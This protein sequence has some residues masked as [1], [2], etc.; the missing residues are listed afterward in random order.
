M[1]FTLK[2]MT[3]ARRLRIGAVVALIL[4]IPLCSYAMVA[5]LAGLSQPA[6]PA[7]P[8]SAAELLA[9]AITGIPLAIALWHLIQMLS[10]IEGGE[11][12]T[13]ATIAHLGGFALFVLISALISILASPII[14]LV[15]LAIDG[16]DPSQIMM[17]FD[18]GDFF[19]LLVSILLFFVVRLLKE[20]QRIA[21]EHRQFV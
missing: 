21:D 6:M 10:R 9:A 1:K 15:R 7:S 17:T 18:G 12:F 2:L 13:S 11:L 20:A 14:A 16:S 3:S 5:G 4:L 19:A 8:S